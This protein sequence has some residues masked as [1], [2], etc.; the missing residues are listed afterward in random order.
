MHA[1]N[2]LAEWGSGEEGCVH[3]FIPSFTQRP[4]RLKEEDWKALDLALGEMETEASGIRTGN[5]GGTFHLSFAGGSSGFHPPLMTHCSAQLQQ[6]VNNPQ[7]N[8]FSFPNSVIYRPGRGCVQGMT[9]LRAPNKGMSQQLGTAPGPHLFTEHSH[10]QEL[11]PEPHTQ[12]DVVAHS[13][14]YLRPKGSPGTPSTA[15]L[16]AGTLQGSSSAPWSR[17]GK[18]KGNT[19]CHCHLWDRGGIL[20]LEQAKAVV[21]NLEGSLEPEQAKG[22]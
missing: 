19:R 13:I 9:L 8:N 17:S 4:T 3:G 2:C 18:G 1:Q 7:V 21:T 11:G 15:F 10:Q 14:P 6:H 20:G 22:C 5:T 16:K 12:L